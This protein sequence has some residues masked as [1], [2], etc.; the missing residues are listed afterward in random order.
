MVEHSIQNS[1]NDNSK[2]DMN[3]SS[4][5]NNH[6]NNTSRVGADSTIRFNG[7][8]PTSE[9]GKTFAS[10]H[11]ELASIAIRATA[12]TSL[13]PELAS[14]QFHHNRRY[15]WKRHPL[16]PSTSLLP[17]RL[18]HNNSNNNN[19]HNNVSKSSATTSGEGGVGDYDD[20]Y[21]EC[22][23][24]VSASR[25]TVTFKR[26]VDKIIISD[27]STTPE[28]GSNIVD[29]DNDDP[30]DDTTDDFDEEEVF[31]VAGAPVPT[32]DDDN[33]IN[34]TL[35]RQE[36][37]HEQQQENSGDIKNDGSDNSNDD[38]DNRRDDHDDISSADKTSDDNDDNIRSGPLL[39]SRKDASDG[40]ANEQQER[41]SHHQH[42]IIDGGSSTPSTIPTTVERDVKDVKETTAAKKEAQQ[43]R[44]GQR[45][46]R[47]ESF[48]SVESQIMDAILKVKATNQYRAATPTKTQSMPALVSHRGPGSS[49]DTREEGGEDERSNERCASEYGGGDNSSRSSRS[50]SRRSIS[51]NPTQE[52]ILLRSLTDTP[53]SQ[54]VDFG[55]SVMNEIDKITS[56]KAKKIYKA[57][58]SST[59]VHASKTLLD[60]GG[61]EEQ[62]VH[63]N[64]SITS[65]IPMEPIWREFKSFEEGTHLLPPATSA[66]QKGRLY[67]RVIAAENLDFPIHSDAPQIRCVLSNGNSEQST[68]FH[69]MKHNISFDHDFYIDIEPSSEFAITLVAGQPKAKSNQFRKLLGNRRRSRTDSI[70]R[71]VNRMDG[72]LAQT[73][74][75][76]DSIES[77]CRS[78]L[79]TASFALIN[80]WYQYARLGGIIPTHKK[81]RLGGGVP[82]KAVGKITVKLFFLPYDGSK[83]EKLPVNMYDCEQALN[84]R[85]YS[86][87]CWQTGYM[88]QLGGDVKFW[89][90]RYFSLRGWRLFSYSDVKRTPRII[91]DLSKAVTLAADHRIIVP[92]R[93]VDDSSSTATGTT[94]TVSHA[95]PSQQGD[96]CS[97]NSNAT[98]TTSEDELVSYSVKNGFRIT[99]KNGESVDFFCDSAKERDGWL[100]V[101][102]VIINRVPGWPDWMDT[103]GDVECDYTENSGTTI[104]VPPQDVR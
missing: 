101:L 72:S 35:E 63:E 69:T 67:I 79:C 58:Q 42:E 37:E 104:N 70:L 96:R 52:P 51:T 83:I 25:K 78:K 4:G 100:E 89:R 17:L 95:H 33:A 32:Q 45:I 86:R 19:I 98:T 66:G 18:S 11:I 31:F 94:T 29:D 34:S 64:G 40:S 61:I 84:V 24:K 75:S 82:E 59:V 12:Q 90:R 6:N 93:T 97:I 76:L 14:A 15:E 41:E 8:I 36:Q 57:R 91:I 55:V 27:P 56:K 92:P 30:E 46:S 73:R 88:S 81:G 38:Y 50:N 77:Q 47:D 7:S 65:A 44:K 22:R 3:A 87:T 10:K 1:T 21:D 53:K 39:L 71:Y 74:V 2:N 49:L 26:D 5:N 85:R 20:D 43:H 28:S 23:T 13:F 99:F 80:G 103:D 68:E 9:L 60:D 62:S 16:S 54:D 102:K 48:Q